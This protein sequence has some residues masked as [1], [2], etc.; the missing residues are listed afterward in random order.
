MKRVTPDLVSKEIEQRAA[1]VRRRWSFSER[2]RRT[3]L[4][5]DMPIRLRLWPVCMDR[6]LMS[7]HRW[8]EAAAYA[9]NRT[10]S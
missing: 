1:Q 3:G 4:P 10:E 5:P 7:G 9:Y 2:I 6:A 8:S